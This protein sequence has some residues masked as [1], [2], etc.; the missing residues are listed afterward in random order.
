M[1]LK[2]IVIFEYNHLEKL[3][4]KEKKDEIKGMH[5]DIKQ[6]MEKTFNGLNKCYASAYELKTIKLSK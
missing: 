6:T 2:F 4:P 3:T 1:K 5:E